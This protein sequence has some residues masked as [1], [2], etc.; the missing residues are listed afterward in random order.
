MSSECKILDEKSNRMSRANLGMFEAD[1]SASLPN[2]QRILDF[3]SLKNFTQQ[4][5]IFLLKKLWNYYSIKREI[6]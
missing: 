4:R 2:L 3:L 6:W 1:L 5:I